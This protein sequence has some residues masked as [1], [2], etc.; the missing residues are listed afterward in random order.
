MRSSLAGTKHFGSPVSCAHAGRLQA[1]E[2]GVN[3]AMS[4]LDISYSRSSSATARGTSGE[5]GEGGE[6]CELGCANRVNQGGKKTKCANEKKLHTVGRRRLWRAT[7]VA[8]N[9]WLIKFIRWLASEQRKQ[10]CAVG[11]LHRRAVRRLLA[12]KLR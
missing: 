10:T 4:T 1:G 9:S 8:R 2:A 7:C 3:P 11:R 12:A 5:A 6:V